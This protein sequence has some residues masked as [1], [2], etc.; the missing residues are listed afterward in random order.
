[1]HVIQMVVVVALSISLTS[2]ARASTTFST[3]AQFSKVGES[4]GGRYGPGHHLAIDGSTVYA[5]NVR[6]ISG[7]AQIGLTLSSNGGGTWQATRILQSGPN[8]DEAVIALGPDPQ[9]PGNSVIHVVWTDRDPT[10]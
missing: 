10:T 4:V 6:T 8:L 5:V 2:D 3:G 9:S 7:E 1:M